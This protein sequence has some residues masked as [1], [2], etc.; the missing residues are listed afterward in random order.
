[1]EYRSVA[2]EYLSHRTIAHVDE[3]RLSPL[4]EVNQMLIADKV[5]N[6]K[7]FELYHKATHPRSAELDL[8]FNNWL[9]RLGITP[10]RYTTLKAL[11]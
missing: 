4:P 3:I 8:Y 2:N 7:D 1:M 11:L 6:C 10:E 5:Q 9:R